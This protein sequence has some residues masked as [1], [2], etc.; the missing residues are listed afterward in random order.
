MYVCLCK[1]VTDRDIEQAVTHGCRSMRELKSELGV[2]AQC[3]R[4][5]SHAREVLVGAGQNLSSG[6]VKLEISNRE[7]ETTP[8]LAT[9]VCY[10]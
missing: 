10:T 3:G 9:E 7:I 4:C 6:V 8:N 2:G 5:T 1:G